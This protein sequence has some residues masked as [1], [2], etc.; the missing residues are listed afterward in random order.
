MTLSCCAPKLDKRIDII[1]KST[2][3][4]SGGGQTET[5]SVDKT[6]WAKLMPRKMNPLLEA[7]NTENQVTHDIVIRYASNLVLS[8]KKRIRFGTRFFG[9]RNIIN[10][11]EQNK[12]YKIEAIENSKMNVTVV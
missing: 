1:K 3:R 8:D 9:I 7:Q 5:W 4:T 2:A 12:Y 6:V 10:V 11:D